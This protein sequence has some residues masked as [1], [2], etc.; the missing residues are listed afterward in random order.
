MAMLTFLV[1]ITVIV[2]SICAG[3]RFTMSLY[4]RKAIGVHARQVSSAGK[5]AYSVSRSRDASLARV[6]DYGLH[7]ARTGFLI[8]AVLM[9]IIVLGLIA[10][11]SAIF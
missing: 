5:E 8:F 11:I 10:L 2:V 4:A 1:T 6:Q 7:Y 3:H 9:A